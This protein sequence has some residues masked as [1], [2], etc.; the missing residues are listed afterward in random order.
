MTSR[1]R[2]HEAARAVG[3]VTRRDL[4]RIVA[5]AAAAAAFAPRTLSAGAP[6]RIGSNENNY[7]LGP[8][9]LTAVRDALPEANRY[10]G[11]AMS[12]LHA[13]LVAAH[14]IDSGWLVLTPGSGEILRAATMAFTSSSRALVAAAPTFE[15]PGRTAEMIGAPVR[16]VPVL[17]SGSLDLDGMAAQAAGAGL[18]FVCN[19]NNPTGGVSTADAIKAFVAR[20][21]A[22][23]PEAVLLMD[24][25]YHDYVEDPGYA[26]AI[27]L[28]RNDPRI[29][30][31]R[32]FSK[33]YGMAGMRV[34]YAI[35]Q[36]ETL[37]AMRRSLSQGALSSVSLG[38]ALASLADREHHAR[39]RALT[40]DAKAFTRKAFVDAGFNVLPSEANFLMVDVRRSVGSFAASCRESGV[41]IARPFPPLNTHA[42][43]SIGTMDEMQRAVAVMLPILR[44]PS[45]AR[46]D[47]S[48]DGAAAAD[49]HVG[50]C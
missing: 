17:A 18:F 8:N 43:I 38:A 16:Q 28:V 29:L 7:G 33:I 27:A 41:F 48:H 46:A 32:T 42:R 21:R 37:R 44:A 4:G 19:P 6:I 3:R 50:G 26:S 45:S 12:R 35:A 20:A 24:E 14:D 15:A 13:A 36:P 23:A 22:A 49:L 34:G 31:S 2:S 9:A 10:G 11:E 25:A 40:R 47:V 1:C 5:S 39:Q 30:V